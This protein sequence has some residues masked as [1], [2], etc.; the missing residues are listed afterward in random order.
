[1]GQGLANILENG[2][3]RSGCHYWNYNLDAH[4]TDHSVKDPVDET[5]KHTASAFNVWSHM[6]IDF[7]CL[8]L[9]PLLLTWFNFNPSMNK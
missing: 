2:A 3:R 5:S 6:F 4:V 1:M 8:H 7:P 9:G